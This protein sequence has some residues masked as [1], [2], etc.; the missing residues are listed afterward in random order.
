MED[1]SCFISDTPR[2]TL[3]ANTGEEPYVKMNIVIIL[4][5]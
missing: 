4:K 1:R 2:V 5:I 3:D